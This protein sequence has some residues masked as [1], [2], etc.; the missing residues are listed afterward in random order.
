VNENLGRTFLYED[1]LKGV[2]KPSD[3]NFANIS[4]QVIADETGGLVLS[5]TDISGI[6]KRCMDDAGPY[7]RMSFEPPPA[8]R[9]DI[10]HSLTVKVDQP[11]LTAHTNTGYYDQP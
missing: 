7:Y 5:S 10:Y 9:R 1:Y 11:G 8:E 3:V 2:K 4:L 6:L